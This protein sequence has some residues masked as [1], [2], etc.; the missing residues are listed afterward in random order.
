MAPTSGAESV[1]GSASLGWEVCSHREVLGQ[2]P[3]PP[4]KIGPPPP[5]P[6]LT[7]LSF[8]GSGPLLGGWGNKRASQQPSSLSYAPPVCLCPEGDGS[9]PPGPV[10]LLVRGGLAPLSEAWRGIK[11][12]REAKLAGRA[13]AP[14]LRPS[15]PFPLGRGGV[16][17]SCSCPPS[18]WGP[19]K[20]GLLSLPAG[21]SAN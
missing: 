15:Q 3:P 2:S 14:P 7:A 4:H 6:P 18:R 10:V 9:A 11:L 19:L 5:F 8:P 16:M 17:P 21:S 1:P 13:S 20:T 12:F